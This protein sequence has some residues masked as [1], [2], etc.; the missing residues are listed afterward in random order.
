MENGVM[1]CFFVCCMRESKKW[2][3]SKKTHSYG[4]RI[5]GQHDISPLSRLIS[6]MLQIQMIVLVAGVLH[7][8][9]ASSSSLDGGTVMKR[10]RISRHVKK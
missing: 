2:N 7:F 8:T 3:K 1:R 5:N 4:P 9:N 6:R 10:R